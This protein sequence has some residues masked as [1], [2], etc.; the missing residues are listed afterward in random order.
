MDEDLASGEFTTDSMVRG[1]HVYQEVWTPITGEYLVCAREEDNLQDRYAVA[2]LKH[3]EI[4]GH[5]PRTISTISSL[6]IRRGGSIQCEVTD[7]RRYSR[8]LPQGGMEV[9]CKLH[10]RADGSELKKVKAYFSKIKAFAVESSTKTKTDGKILV[11]DHETSTETDSIVVGELKPAHPHSDHE[12]LAIQ[13]QDNDLPSCA[14]SCITLPDND[15][16]LATEPQDV[17]VVH[18]N[19]TLTAT[20]KTKIEQGEHL[21]DKHMQMAQHLAKKQFPLA[22][23]LRSTLLQ[24]KTVKGHKGQCTANTVQIIHCEKRSHWIV[25]STIFAKSGCV[26]IYDTMFARLDAETRATVK[27]IFGLKSVEGLNMVDMQCQEG[28]SD[29]GVFAIA[30]ITSLLFGED[31]SMVTYK[32]EKLREHLTEC[33]T[34]GKLSLFPKN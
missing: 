34:V 20:D 2:V 10:F 13:K 6:F 3:D 4:I 29:C 28:T 23:G 7:H 27:R 5:L 33:L 15:S 26:N 30:V 9:P 17:W 21:T 8:D 14:T 11:T 24:Q 31:P 32:Q 1:H 22:G 18:D 12:S 25:A 19:L 16:C